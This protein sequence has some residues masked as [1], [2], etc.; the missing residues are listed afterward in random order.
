MEVWETF[1]GLDLKKKWF[2][3]SHPRKIWFSHSRSLS[4]FQLA[5]W[6]KRYLIMIRISRDRRFWLHKGFR[7]CSGQHS[8]RL[9]FDHPKPW[10]RLARGPSWGSQAWG[11]ESAENCFPQR[12]C[13]VENDMSFMWIQG[14]IWVYIIEGICVT[15][16]QLETH[17][18]MWKEYYHRG[19]YIYIDH[20]GMTLKEKRT[21][22]LGKTTCHQN[23]YG[24]SRKSLGPKRI[25][26]GLCRSIDLS[27]TIS[28]TQRC[29]DDAMA[30]IT[31]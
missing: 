22:P 3:F 12:S 13:Y 23:L 19:I 4:I 6:R 17:I 29:Q 14:T 16:T 28:Q 10:F 27:P 8:L 15:E 24:V 31:I 11:E 30:A 1:W 5:R 25:D 9:S 18:Y 21:R 2:R 7:I 26:Q 20:R